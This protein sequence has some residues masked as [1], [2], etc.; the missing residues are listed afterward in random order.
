[1]NVDRRVVAKFSG[2]LRT[3]VRLAVAHRRVPRGARA[4]L[5]VRARPCKGRRH[6]KVRLRRGKRRIAARRLNRGCVA[7]FRPR[8]RRRA[9]FTVTVP[10]D[11]HHFAGRSVTVTVVP[12]G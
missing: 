7:R 1:M 10:G 9:R 4:L 5:R 6:D 2:P 3:R 8:I 11:S 12:R